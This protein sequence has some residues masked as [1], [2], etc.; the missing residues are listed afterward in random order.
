MK[1][2]KGRV[3]KEKKSILRKLFDKLVNGRKYKRQKGCE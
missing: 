3:R 1:I 2:I